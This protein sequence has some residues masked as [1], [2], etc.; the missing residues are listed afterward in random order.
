MSLKKLNSSQVK[1]MKHENI[2]YFTP[3]EAT[4]INRIQESPD[5]F[6]LFLKLTNP[7][8]H[9][10]YKQAIPGQFVMVYCYGIGE[11]PISIADG[12]TEDY[13]CQLTIRAHG[14]VT[15]KLSALQIGESVGLRGP[16]GQ[17]W[18]LQQVQ[19]KDVI[20][21]TGGI[22]CAPTLGAIKHILRYRHQYGATHILHG[23]KQ[24]EELIYRDDYQQWNEVATID[25][26]FTA[27]AN[28]SPNWHTGYVT[29]LIDQLKIPKP[30]DT[31]CFICGP[32][33]MMIKAA[34]QLAQRQL[35]LNNI[36]LSLERNM[37]CGIG[38]CGHC[39]CGSQFICKD[40]PVFSYEKIRHKIRN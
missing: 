12:F 30:S 2:N 6:S 39:Q 1:I 19:H 16:F 24:S 8:L 23:V 14:L 15:R 17:G 36:F 18:P 9:Q 5:I 32:E 21:I 29:T 38:H 20:I 7:S 26:S 4:I 3:G 34:E 25:I 37:H 35:A 28:P 11:V 31:V 10:S 22:G 13:S 27:E 40:G 33:I